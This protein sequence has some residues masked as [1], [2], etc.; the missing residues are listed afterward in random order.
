MQHRLKEK[1]IFD[2]KME[3]K[4]KMIEEK[5]KENE[6]LNLKRKQMDHWIK[7]K[8]KELKNKK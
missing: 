6:S 5:I 3:I 1:L 7:V 2:A 8:E 4:Q